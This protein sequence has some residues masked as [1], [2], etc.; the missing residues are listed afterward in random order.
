LAHIVIHELFRASGV[1]GEDGASIDDTYQLTIGLYRL[2]KLD[3]MGNVLI[4]GPKAY[5]Q[6]QCFAGEYSTPVMGSTYTDLSLLAE[7]EAR[8]SATCEE[9]GHTQVIGRC[10]RF[11]GDATQDPQKNIGR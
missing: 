10:L 8:M 1:V 2:N 11:F 9:Q 3:S 7:A 4:G 6:C 5:W